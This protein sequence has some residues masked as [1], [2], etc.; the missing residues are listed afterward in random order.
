MLSQF[1]RKVATA[2]L[3][4]SAGIEREKDILVKGRSY[5]LETMENAIK[6]A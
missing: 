2:G 4:R 1:H 3:T 5:H 6:Q